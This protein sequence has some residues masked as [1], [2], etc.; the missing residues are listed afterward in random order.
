MSKDIRIFDGTKLWG[1]TSNRD[2]R[3]EDRRIALTMFHRAELWCAITGHAQFM[4]KYA[5]KGALLIVL[6]EEFSEIDFLESSHSKLISIQFFRVHHSWQKHCI[7]LLGQSEHAVIVTVSVQ[8][9][10]WRF[11]PAD[12]M[13]HS[14]ILFERQCISFHSRHIVSAIQNIKSP[15]VRG[16]RERSLILQPVGQLGHWPYAVESKK[17]RW[18]AA[19][20]NQP[21]TKTILYNVTC[22]DLFQL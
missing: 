11:V 17:C 20:V 15:H 22:P 4:S 2:R 7:D 18:L 16:L 14:A 21:Q 13:T 10:T 12:K 1:R 5:W 19:S 3:Y 6:L 8:C 9:W